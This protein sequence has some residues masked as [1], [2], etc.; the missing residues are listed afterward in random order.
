MP[1]KAKARIGKSIVV[2]IAAFFL[3]SALGWFSAK[4]SLPDC[5]SITR[6]DLIASGNTGPDFDGNLVT[7]REIEVGGRIKYPFVVET[8]YMVPRGL[9]GEFHTYKYFVFFG[10]VKRYDYITFTS[11]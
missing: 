1:M 10:F 11:V 7:Y 9:H 4:L 2:L 8:Y 3:V 5:L 6:Q